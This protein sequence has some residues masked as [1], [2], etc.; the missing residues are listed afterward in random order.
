MTLKGYIY[1]F[2]AVIIVTLLVENRIQSGKIDRQKVEIGR[3]NDNNL[4]LMA[5]NRQQTTMY[6]KEKEVT[7]RIKVE[8]DSLAKSLKIAPKQI[9]KIVEVKTVVHDTIRKEVPVQAI[10]KDS[11][12]ISDKGECW[13]WS[14]VA[15]LKNDSLHVQRQNFEYDNTTTPVYYRVRPHKFLFIKYGKW[16][17]K[18]SVT[19]KCGSP[20]ITEFNFIK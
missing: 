12:K 5:D 18:V 16:V 15:S 1:T 2:V 9:T 7:G 14:G 13:S 6:L 3:L 4:Q 19:S 17:N 20:S 11:W 10:G 8:R